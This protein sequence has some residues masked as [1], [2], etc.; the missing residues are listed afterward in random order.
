MTDCSASCN[1]DLCV[2]VGASFRLPIQWSSLPLVYK[3]VTASTDS[4]PLTLTVPS[5]G[6]VDGWA[7]A[8]RDFAGVLKE[9]NAADW[10]PTQ[11]DF[12]IATVVDANTIVL[13]EVDAGAYTSGGIVAYFTPISLAG[14][15]G[16]F[17]IYPV[18]A[19]VGT[20]P[21]PFLSVALEFDDALKTITAA[22]TNVDTATMTSPTYRYAMFVTDVDGVVTVL[23]EGGIRTRTPGSGQ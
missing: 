1:A 16:L 10:P 17:N 12:R 11:D 21:V 5:H 18:P 3:D 22:L 7:V 8:L 23:R 14:M 9:L 20:P 19:P 4:A 2:E 15:S 13:N 6:L